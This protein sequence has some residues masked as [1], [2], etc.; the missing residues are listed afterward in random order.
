MKQLFSLVAILLFAFACGPLPQEQEAKSAVGI[1]APD[2]FSVACV[3]GFTRRLPHLCNF[4]SA[5]GAI[6]TQTAIADGVCRSFD[7]S[8]TVLP[9]SARAVR[10]YVRIVITSTNAI[11]IKGVS[12]GPFVDAGCTTGAHTFYNQIR[13]F[14]AVAA[15]TTIFESY[16]PF[17]Y[18]PLNADRILTYTATTTGGASSTAYLVILGYY[19]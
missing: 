5:A 7:L 13:E 18:L 3:D 2:G 19:D 11:S 9:T 10:G 1:T 8:A 4:S 15:N 6:A 17:D 14:A 16:I 12:F